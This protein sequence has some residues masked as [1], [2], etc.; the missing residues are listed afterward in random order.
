MDITKQQLI[1]R[2]SRYKNITPEKKRRAVKLIFAEQVTNY[3]QL[4]EILGA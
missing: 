4:T 3:S 2:L 1:E